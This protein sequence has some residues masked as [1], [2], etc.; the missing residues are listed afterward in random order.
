MVKKLINKLILPLI[1]NS[2]TSQLLNLLAFFV[3]T[4]YF[5]INGTLNLI[6]VLL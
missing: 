4:I 2:I 3:F 6:N 5:I 1:N